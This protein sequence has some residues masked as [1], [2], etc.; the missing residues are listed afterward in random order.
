M[1]PSPWKLTAGICL[2]SAIF[3]TGEDLPPPTPV[4]SFEL[5]SEVDAPVDPDVNAIAVFDD[6]SWR[7]FIAIN[8]PTKPGIRGVPDEAKKIGDFCDPGTKVVWG[9]WKADYELFQQ[10]GMEPTE[11]SSFDGFSPC[12]CLLYTS[13]SPR[14]VSTSRM[15]SSG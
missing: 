15:P 12:R 7:A 1:N 6:Y 8:W 3:A 4:V 5:P 2:L 9:T 11:W 14:D 10:E 13:P